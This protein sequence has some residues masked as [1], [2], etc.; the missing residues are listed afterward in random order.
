MKREVSV[1]L[2][3]LNLHGTLNFP[4][5]VRAWVIFVHG[6]GSSHLSPRNNWVADQLNACGF[7]TLLFDLLTE[8]ED[9]IYLNRF[10]L[11]MLSARLIGATEWLMRRPEYQGEKLAYFGAS[12]G[13]GAA[14]LAASKI[15]N[16][17]PLFAVVS[18]G[19]RPDLVR[20][21]VLHEVTVPTLLI[22]GGHDGEVI[23][24]NENADRHL[25][26]S[27]VA[28]VPGATHLFEEPGALDEVVN[29]SRVWL[30]RFLQSSS[31]QSEVRL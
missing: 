8:D 10:D 29:L 13:A 1:Q 17:V 15:Q 31:D 19:G 28:I 21:E 26:I 6:S 12:T 22:V 24:M 14:L 4:E 23:R 9:E 27:K 2:D 20:P 7:G 3:Q 18:R 11:P 5:N 16:D 25:S 30:E